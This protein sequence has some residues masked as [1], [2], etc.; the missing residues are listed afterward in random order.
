MGESIIGIQKSILE[1]LF[2]NITFFRSF[3]RIHT[4]NA[5][6]QNA[7]C[8]KHGYQSS[9]KLVWCNV[10]RYVG[11]LSWFGALFPGMFDSYLCR[12]DVHVYKCCFKFGKAVTFV[13]SFFFVRRSGVPGST[14]VQRQTIHARTKGFKRNYFLW[15]DL[16]NR[17]LI[18]SVGSTT[19][20][21]IL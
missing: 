15:L 2:E 9:P 20:E 16:N 3:F 13:F 21:I 12:V 6:P 18:N 11:T 7:K 8:I 14:Y 17:T 10:S 4:H 5:I 1:V 19:V